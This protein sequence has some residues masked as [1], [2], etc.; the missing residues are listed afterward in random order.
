MIDSPEC[1]KVINPYER[2]KWFSKWDPLIQLI[3]KY[4]NT[5]S[6]HEKEEV[7]LLLNEDLKKN[8]TLWYPSAGFD[9]TDIINVNNDMFAE[10]GEDSP[11]VFLHNDINN[12]IV[13]FNKKYKNV[14]KFPRNP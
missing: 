12:Y 10:F 2:Q 6:F 4:L 3:A 8:Q 11:L 5:D 14:N 13:H 7:F 9:V 1:I